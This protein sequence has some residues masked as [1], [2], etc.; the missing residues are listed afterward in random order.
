M[1]RASWSKKL[2]A[3]A[4]VLGLAAFASAHTIKV[5][6]SKQVVEEAG[7]KT[8]VY[9]SWGDRVPV[10][11][12]IDA[13]ALDRY[14][15]LTPVNTTTALKKE[16][17]SLQTNVVELKDPGLYQ[18]LVARKPATYTTIIDEDGKKQ[19]KRGP[20]TAIKEGKIDSS[21][22]SVQTGKSIILVGRNVTAAP[23]PAGL[24]VEIVPLDAPAA[25]KTGKAVRF[26]VLL[27]GKPLAGAEFK[28]RPLGFKPDNAWSYAT[29]T[30]RQG[31]ATVYPNQVGT[32]IFN[33]HSKLPTAGA[34]REQYD[35][36]SY[37]STLSLEIEP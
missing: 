5:F 34:T 26:Q 8:T 36:D 37:T 1:N 14:D 3:L 27:D 28:A 11:D 10:D 23:K 13:S 32:W 21:L 19:V 17:L 2:L 24:P 9:L 15:L 31:I 30:N 7:G 22:R 16:E 33:A 25:W 12:L 35:F 4:L 18:V 20:K 29:T 6:A